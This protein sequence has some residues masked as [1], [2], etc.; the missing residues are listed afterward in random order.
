MD[1]RTARD[2][3]ALVRHRRRALGWSQAR[4]AA[5]TGTSRDWIIQFEKAKSTVELGLALRALKAVGVA[6]QVPEAAENPA[7]RKRH[8]P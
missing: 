4:L 7:R 8:H 3:A 6:L 1:V 2:L 5:E